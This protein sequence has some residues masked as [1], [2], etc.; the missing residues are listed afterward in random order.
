MKG[1]ISAINRYFNWRNDCLFKAP[2]FPVWCDTGAAVESRDSKARHILRTDGAVEGNAEI[3]T[4]LP[5][6]DHMEMSGFYCSSIISYGATRNGFIRLHRHV[7]FP[8]LRMR[9]NDTRG[10]LSHNFL[11][12][13]Q[14]KILIDGKHLGLE[15]M[16]R[17][18][19]DGMLTLRSASASDLE[20]ERTLFPAVDQPALIERVTL[21]VK[22]GREHQVQIIPA[23]YRRQTRAARGVNG[24]YTLAAFLSDEKG[25]ITSNPRSKYAISVSA[26]HPHVF[27]IA[28]CATRAGHEI[29]F[30]AKEEEH[31]RRAF[32]TELRGN[33]RLE[34]PNCALN[35]AMEFAKIRACESI[36]RTKNGLMHAPGGGS[37]YAALWT[38]DQC[39]YT[40]PLFPL[41]GYKVGLEQAENSFRLFQ[42]RMD[43]SLSH[44]LVSSII[45]EG[46]GVWNGAGDRGDGAMFAYGAA[47]YALAHGDKKAADQ[48]WNGIVWGIEYS[49]KQKNEEGVIRSD[50]DE[51]ENRFPSGDANLFT[52]CLVYDAL[53]SAAYLAEE[54]Q[55][56]AQLSSRYRAEAEALK[57][58]IERYF[59]ACV[60]GYD[61]YQ[62]YKGNDVLRAWI[63]VPLTVGILTRAKETLNALW[64]ERLW[65]ED[66]LRSQAGCDTFWDRATLF[67]LRGAFAMGDREQAHDRLVRYTQRRLLGE[68]VPYAVEAWPEGN[69]KHLSAE[70][71]LYIR[72][73]TEGLFGIRP[74]GL[75]SFTL[76]PQLPQGWD[77]M[78]LRDIR[79]FGSRFSIEVRRKE[80]EIHVVI[81]SNGVNI[82]NET[83][84]NGACIPVC[85]EK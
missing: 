8:M 48:L 57:D 30:S 35:T 63:C 3:D 83:I 17:V 21:R 20:I 18:T 50:S 68:H 33:L 75:R 6:A 27:Y 10:S 73:F 78:A 45:A 55:K 25:T 64:S 1:L 47:R 74:T 62:Y 7:V 61:T 71:A 65:S 34:T 11:A 28:Y 42:E 79:A 43:D 72:V 16:I 23:N 41:I 70:S 22:D 36:F 69:Q 14:P 37:F 29:S 67:A 54:L 4:R 15:R 53:L 5:Y 58:A 80:T 38:N 26:E 40:N 60:E 32:L 13:A 84:Q 66:G 59:G 9:P 19:L 2:Y 39:E 49:L 76:R 52:S 85:L 46:E 82:T 24:A 81:E 44:P 77:H 12:K 51:L 31:K 56:G